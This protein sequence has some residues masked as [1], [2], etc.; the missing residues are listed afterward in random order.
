[1]DKDSEPSDV[2]RALSPASWFSRN[3]QPNARPAVN[4]K[5]WLQTKKITSW[6]W[7]VFRSGFLH[8][9]FRTKSFL[10]RRKEIIFDGKHLRALF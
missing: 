7:E 8:F 2:N 10:L 4:L 9:F 3:G 6:E 5:V 1:M